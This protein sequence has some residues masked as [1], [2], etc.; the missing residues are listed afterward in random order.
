[1]PRA[2]V[3]ALPMPPPFICVPRD[4]SQGL[5]SPEPEYTMSVYVSRMPPSSSNGST[6]P[7][8]GS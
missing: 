4:T 7:V 1:M 2:N 3:Y 6:I 8:C 5:V